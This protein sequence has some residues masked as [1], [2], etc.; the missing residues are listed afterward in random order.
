M[1]ERQREATATMIL[2]VSCARASSCCGA[3][4][5]AYLCMCV[6]WGSCLRLRRALNAVLS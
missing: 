1:G 4:V 2:F 5:C 3:N 6:L